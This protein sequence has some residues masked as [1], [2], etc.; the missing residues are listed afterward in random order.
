MKVDVACTLGSLLL[1]NPIMP[2]SGCYDWYPSSDEIHP[3]EFGAIV[4]KSV[5]LY[6]RT[7]NPPPRIAETPQGMLNAIGIPSDGARV[8]IHE[9]RTKWSQVT[10]PVIAS[11][12]AAS[13]QEYA[14]VA[15][16]L[17]KEP[18]IAALEINL[19]CPNLHHNITPAQDP[20]LLKECLSAVRQA[21]TKVIIAKLSP[22]VTSIAKMAAI[23]EAE[24]ADAISLINTVRGMVIDI[25]ARRPLL[26]NICGGLSGPAI[27]PIAVAMVYE[28]YSTVNIPIVGVGGICQAEDALEF[29]LAGA[30]AVQIG[31]GLFRNPHAARTVLAGIEHYLT[32]NGFSSIQELIGLAQ[33]AQIY[34]Q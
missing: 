12:S 28:V 34:R 11:I 16:L 29:F 19:S 8:F 32:I 27:K 18:A 5:T 1:K 10:V 14:E 6:P 3:D 20:E 15:A 26:G 30:S 24:K 7:G 25:H 9:V 22:N 2:A 33:T 13:P 17:D 31:S 21:T 23:C 4:L